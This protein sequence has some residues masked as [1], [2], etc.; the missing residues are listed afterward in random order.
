MQTNS[1]KTDIKFTV[2]RARIAFLGL[3][4]LLLLS[5]STS[6]YA[7]F[8]GGEINKKIIAPYKK[9]NQSLSDYFKKILS[10]EDKSSPKPPINNFT[11]INSTSEAKIIIDDKVYQS[12]KTTAVPK[13]TQEYKQVI[14]FVYPTYI[15][16]TAVPGQPGSKEW[17]EEFRKKWDE[18][19]KKNAE[20]Q[21]QVEE[22]QKKFCQDNPNLC[23]K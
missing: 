11:I 13:K 9:F 19:S 3:I 5:S 22:S 17:D 8:T 10:E 1:K 4:I 18:M 14:E 2:F 15:I 12:P 21:K 23:N 7:G 20:M 6:L 16:P